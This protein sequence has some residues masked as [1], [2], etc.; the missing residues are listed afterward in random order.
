MKQVEKDLMIVI[1]VVIVMIVLFLITIQMAKG[2][3]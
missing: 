3:M 1:S 2:G